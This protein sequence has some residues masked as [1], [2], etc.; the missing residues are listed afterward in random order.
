[1]STYEYQITQACI[2]LIKQ[3]EGCRYAA[4]Q[5][6]VGIWTVG[7][8]HTGGV[9]PD[10]HIDQAQAEQLLQLDVSKTAARIA[11][12]LTVPLN[13][14]QF[15]AL[16]SFAFNLGVTAF[17]NS[18]LCRLVNEGQTGQVITDEFNKWDHAG[19]HMVEGLL[20]RR[21]AEA[22]LFNTPVEG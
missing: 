19:G 7:Y 21:E 3:F 13:S 5:D 12:Y 9:F 14:N 15:G 6:V 2:D 11:D 1:M 17:Q 20:R 22:A 16:V 4:Y 8:G 18:T 10:T